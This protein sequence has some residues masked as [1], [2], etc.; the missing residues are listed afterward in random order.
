MSGSQNGKILTF[1]SYKGGT[2][3]SMLLANVAWILAS[4]G[5]RV[6]MIDWDLEAPGLHHYFRPFLDDKDLISSNGVINLVVQYQENVTSLAENE[7]LSDDWYRREGDILSW[8]NALNWDFGAGELH[9]VPAG[10]QVSSYAALVNQFD[11]NQLYERLG[12][13]RFFEA[14]KEQMRAE[15]DYVLI[16]SRTG[17]SDTSGLCTVQMPD[18]LVACFTLNRQSLE[19]AA[20]V[21]EAVTKQRSTDSINGSFRVFPVAS[22]VE[23]F[24]K[25]KLEQARAAARKAFDGYLS[26]LGSSKSVDRYWGSVE[27]LYEPFYAYEEI[28]AVFGDRPSQL[29]SLLASVERLTGY[30]TENHVVEAPP[31]SDTKRELVLKRYSRMFE[32]E[33]EEE[34]DWPTNAYVSDLEYDVY[35]SYAHIDN[36]PLSPDLKGWVSQLEESLRIR[37]AQLTGRGVA[38]WRDRK[39]QGNDVLSATIE[40][41]LQR[42]GVFVVVLTPAYLQSEWCL[43]E[44]GLFLRTAEKRRPLTT[45]NK[46]MIFKVLRAPVQREMEP[47]A[48]QSTLGYRFYREDKESSVRG[49][50]LLAQGRAKREF[51]ETLDDLA[52]DI[53]AVLKEMRESVAGSAT[54]AVLPGAVFLAETT[55]DLA[56]E[57]ELI[58][59]YLLQRGYEVLP[60]RRLPTD[61][62]TDL[63]RAVRTDLKRSM[64]SIHLIGK[65]YGIIP[66]GAQRSLPAIQLEL[67]ADQSRDAGPRGL[68]WIPPNLESKEALQQHLL[69]RLVDGQMAAGAEVVQDSLETLKSIIEDKL[70]TAPERATE[71]PATGSTLIYLLH[72]RADAE[73]AELLKDFL[74]DQ[75]FEVAW[76][77]SQGPPGELR[78][79]H[80]NILETCDA[81][82]LYFGEASELWLRTKLLDLRKAYGKRREP[83]QGTMIYLST[84]KNAQK[85]R[86]RTREAMVIKNYGKPNGEALAPFL[87]QLDPES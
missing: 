26:H 33:P 14:I 15:Y 19:G 1:Y 8:A 56:S 40:E 55:S 80:E 4:S 87:A 30:L 59:R 76:P 45:G 46:S 58:R 21:V 43:R 37:L 12:G 10:R 79:F 41:Q 36:K 18:V 31:I 32:N 22:R 83:F 77:P 42:V 35:I 6:L 16:D 13:Y 24:E 29:T 64:F 73:A 2:G 5:K 34:V 63:L 75:G 44:V 47:S 78:Q 23:K 7:Q 62:V 51:L 53:S 57:R 71:R 82:V 61:K 81:V 50:S 84:P 66:E 38:I 49:L 48:L 60:D 70:R 9:F 54:Q 72:D 67:A 52:H 11:W 69:K 39:L 85:E 74:F 3:R 25:D 65:H 17:V 86:F 68:I 20:S 27:I 28:L